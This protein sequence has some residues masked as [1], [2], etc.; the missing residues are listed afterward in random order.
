MVKF[1]A[2]LVVKGYNK[3]EGIDFLYS[4][5]HVAKLVT[6]RILI[7]IGTTKRWNIQQLDINNAFLHRFSTWGS[8]YGVPRRLCKGKASRYASY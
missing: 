4:F 6:A 1:K 7:A 8:I 5:S 3:I 2:R